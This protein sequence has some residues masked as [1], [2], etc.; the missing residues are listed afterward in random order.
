MSTGLDDVRDCMIGTE[1][2]FILFDSLFSDQAKK[3]AFI[4]TSTTIVLSTDFV[5]S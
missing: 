5:V 4:T 1:A 3:L 2:A